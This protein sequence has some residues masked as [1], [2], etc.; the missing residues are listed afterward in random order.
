MKLGCGFVLRLECPHCKRSVSKHKP[1]CPMFEYELAVRMLDR[2]I[3]DGNSE[4]AIASL[5]ERVARASQR[6]DELEL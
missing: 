4:K 1:S 5:R 3:D 2:S 6:L